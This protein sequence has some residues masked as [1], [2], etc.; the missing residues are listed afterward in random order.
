MKQKA[1]FTLLACVALVFLGLALGAVFK[2]QPQQSLYITRVV[3]GDTFHAING[4]GRSEKYRLAYVDAPELTSTRYGYAECYG[5]EADSFLF[6]Q[7]SNTFVTGRI[8][9]ADRYGRY[10]IHIDEIESRM[11]EGGYAKVYKD[12]GLPAIYLEL[13]AAARQDSIGLWGCEE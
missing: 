7:Y 6:D 10:V 4:H 12:K 13:E 8:L 11:L 2:Q 5:V 3:D 1:A 9:K